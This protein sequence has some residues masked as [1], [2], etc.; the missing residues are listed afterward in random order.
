MDTFS[1]FNAQISKTI[2]HSNIA[3]ALAT[4]IITTITAI[5]SIIML[6]HTTYKFY[7]ED[8]S[9]ILEDDTG[10]Y[11]SRRSSGSSTNK[12]SRA[13]L[14]KVKKTYG[15]DEPHHKEIHQVIAFQTIL[16]LFMGASYTL[17]QSI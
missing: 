4:F 12:K 9:H 5:I 13:K 3:E 6:S 10:D 17:T 7:V 11:A 1:L 14:P 2:Y 15:A 8:I 16:F